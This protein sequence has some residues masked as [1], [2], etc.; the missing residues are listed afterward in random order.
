M[1]PRIVP[2]LVL[3]VSSLAGAV[4]PGTA[5]DPARLSLSQGHE[6]ELRGA[7]RDKN[8]SAAEALLANAIAERTGDPALMAAAGE[9]SFHAGRYLSAARALKRADRL[10]PLSAFHRFALVNAFIAIERR[11]WARPELERLIRDDPA[12]ANYPY[13]LA[14]I[15]LHYQWF[16]KAEA[17]TRR[18]LELEASNAAGWE[19]LGECLEG[20]GELDAA[21]EG[22]RKAAALHGRR[23]RAA[24]RAL[25]L[26]GSLEHDR[27]ELAEAA[28][29]LQAAVAADPEHA[30]AH[31]ELGQVLRK[32]GHPAK[33]IA[34]LQK[35]AQLDPSNA[36][37]YYALGMAL[38]ASGDVEAATQALRRFRELSQ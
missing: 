6:R 16:A 2:L 7:L 27:G 20:Q 37:S 23:T 15:Y 13:W 18:S 26:L 31:Y 38:R 1:K 5:I 3:A 11:H 22:Y 12:N 9:V 14:G 32:H 25:W 30:L 28:K 29:V 17:E 4:V 21:A 19:R 24:A 34:A 8:W 10:E 33:A 36:R 35:A